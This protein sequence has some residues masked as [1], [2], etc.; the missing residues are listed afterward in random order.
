[1]RKL[2]M[3]LPLCSLVLA[4]ALS[5]QEPRLVNANV[6]TRSA[7]GGLES[8]VQAAVAAQ[9][10]PAWVAYAVPIIPGNHHICCDS[11]EQR[12]LPAPL[13]HGVCRLEGRDD[14]MNFQTN[15]ESGARERPERLLVLCRA[16]DGRISK[17]RVFTDDC[18]LD[19]GGLTVHWLEGVRSAESL[20][21]LAGHVAKTGVTTKEA[22]RITDS[23]LAAIALHADPG[24]DALLEKF[25]GPAHPLET[26]KNAVFWLGNVRGGPGC[27]IVRRVL[28]TDAS[29]SLREQCL[30][31][32]SISKAPDAVPIMIAAARQDHS[33]HVRGQALFWLAQKAGEKA[34][35]AI[36]DAAENDPETGVKKKAVF[37]LSQL[38]HA[39]GVPKLIEV[40]RK[41][42]NREVRKEAMFWLGQS[43]DDRALAFFEEVLVK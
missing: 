12:R 8:A 10:Q 30:F 4:T 40:A 3:I 22:L 20:A 15:D 14:G 24:A 33:A 5:A 32:L 34:V 6:Q 36:A 28:Q 23:A 19:A 18:E 29:D 9:S 2:R 35:N 25:T 16:V 27:E 37:A 7:A 13:R 42:K 11:S 38:P 43:N 39:E 41:N 21:R 31:A 17:L 26:R 1:M